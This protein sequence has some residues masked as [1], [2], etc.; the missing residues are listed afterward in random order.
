VTLTIKKLDGYFKGH[1]QAD[2]DTI[3]VA[4]SIN[5]HDVENSIL[6]N[7]IK[8]LPRWKLDAIRKTCTRGILNNFDRNREVKYGNLPRGM[9]DEQ[10]LKFFSTIR[11]K[12]A[13]IEFFIQFF[14]ALRV[15][16][17]SR[18]EIIQEHNIVKVY[19]EKTNKIQFLPLYEPIKTFLLENKLEV[20][21]TP[22]YLRKVFRRVC[23]EAGINLVYDRSTTGKPL[24]LNTTHSLRHAAI[25]RFAEAVNGDPFKVSM[26]SRHSVQ[27]VIGVQSVYRY[28]SMDDM[29]KD[30][31][32]CFQKYDSLFKLR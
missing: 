7:H 21:H 1:L 28:Y 30:L 4:E 29:A 25:N 5:K 31:V 8:E 16:E 23:D 20:K 13:K 6:Y 11:N 15:G 3:N 2:S 18:A 9:T 10:L 17:I 24:Y 12:D 22:N 14:F 27:S 19:S 26:F 32:R